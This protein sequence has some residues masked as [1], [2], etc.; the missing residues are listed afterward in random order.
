MQTKNTGKGGIRTVCI[1]WC[2]L[3]AGMLSGCGGKTEEKIEEPA[4]PFI[5]TLDGNE[6]AVGCTMQDLANKGYEFSDQSGKQFVTSESG[7]MEYV[8]VAVADL[9]A[10]AEANTVYVT[11]DMLKDM[12]RVASISATNSQENDIPFAECIVDSVAVYSSDEHI[13]T[14][15]V[16]GIP[17]EQLTAEALTEIYGEPKVSTDKSQKWTRGDYY[18]ELGY[19]DGELWYIRSSYTGV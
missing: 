3:L 6:V 15:A 19:Q 16:E 2:V 11:I 18:F 12:E 8:Y 5:I 7:S 13:D 10:E 1:A 4:E 9:S 17:F 14:V